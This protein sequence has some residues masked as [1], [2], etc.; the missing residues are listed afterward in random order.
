MLRCE[1]G[2]EA[3]ADDRDALA[4]SV[5]RHAWQIHQMA[6]SHGDALLL[7]RRAETTSAPAD[8]PTTT[9]S[10]EAG[11]AVKARVDGARDRDGDGADHRDRLGERGTHEA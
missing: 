9:T 8:E 1:C 6:L 5:R 7:T 4:A 10:E 3:R 11:D 2:F